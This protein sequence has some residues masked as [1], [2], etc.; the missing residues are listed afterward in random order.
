[1]DDTVLKNSGEGRLA[2]L[3]ALAVLDLGPYLTG[4]AGAAERLARELRAV[5]EYHGF[6]Y[7]KNH[8]IPQSKIDGIFAETERFH[9]QDQEAKN[10]VTI[11]QNQRGYIKPGATLVSHS[12]YNKNTK[13]DSNETLV[14]ATEYDSDDPGV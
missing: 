11:D 9:A 12:T 14:L 4:E 10:A 7:L 6:F 2:E 8:G 13:F 1:M 3:D 5:C